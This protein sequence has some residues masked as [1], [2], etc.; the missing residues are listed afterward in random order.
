MVSL[1]VSAADEIVSRRRLP[2]ARLP[3][4][5]FFTRPRSEA[6]TTTPSSRRTRHTPPVPLSTTPS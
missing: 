3:E 4:L 6:S 5:D 2:S 1:S